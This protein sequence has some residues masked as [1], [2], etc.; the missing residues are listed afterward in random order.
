[1][2]EFA[3]EVARQSGQ[4]VRYQDLPRAGHE[5]A[6]LQA[7][8]PEPVANLLADSDAK[9]ANGALFDDSGVL[10]RLI[11]RRSR[12]RRRCP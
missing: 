7:N 5:A 12:A 2:T 8:L 9:A 4:P 6:L 11:R 3:A 1:M 10:G